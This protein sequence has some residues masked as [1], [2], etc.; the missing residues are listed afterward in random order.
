MGTY[1]YTTFIDS[2]GG[3][4]ES[5]HLY[6]VGRIFWTDR[7]KVSNSFILKQQRQG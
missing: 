6:L 2:T 4:Q 5:I 3:G 1:I 7:D